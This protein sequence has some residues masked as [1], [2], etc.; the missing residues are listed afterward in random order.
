MI[1]YTCN[2]HSFY[3]VFDFD[4]LMYDAIDYGLT[5]EVCAITRDITTLSGHQ[6]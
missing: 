1:D 2:D 3:K 6:L 4:L 5:Y